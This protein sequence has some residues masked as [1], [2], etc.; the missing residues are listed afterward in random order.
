MLETDIHSS[1]TVSV[2]TVVALRTDK[3][4]AF[5]AAFLAILT[6]R[7]GATGILLFLEYNLHTALLSFI[8]EQMASVACGPLMQALISGGAVVDPL[9]DIFHIADHHCLHALFSQRGNQGSGLLMFNRLDLIFDFL[10]L[11][12]F[13][14]DELVAPP[15]PTLLAINLCGEMLFELV[16]I[17][18]L[19]AQESAIEDVSM[20]PIM[21]DRHVDLTEINASNPLILPMEI[22]WQ[23]WPG[24]RIGGNGFVLAA[25]PMDHNGLGERIRP[26]QE[27]RIIASPIGEA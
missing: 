14:C 23:F 20:L 17:L 6:D 8:G 5:G 15:R 19:V 18:A 22:L 1:Y 3:V 4:S 13:G 24:E 26:E 21:R 10:E 2:P 12:L 9:A 16:L 11:F 27:Q 25:G 7:T